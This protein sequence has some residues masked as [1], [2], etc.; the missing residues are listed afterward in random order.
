MLNFKLK[1][2]LTKKIKEKIMN[3]CRKQVQPKG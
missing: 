3:V 1:K 2:G